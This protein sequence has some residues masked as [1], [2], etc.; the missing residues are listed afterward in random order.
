VHYVIMG[1]GVIA[2]EL[3]GR[4]RRCGQRVTVTT[5]TATRTAEILATGAE[6]VVL[7]PGRPGLGPYDPAAVHAVVAGSDGVVI[8]GR[9][10]LRFA[11]SPRERFTAY[12]HAL[13]NTVRAVTEAQRRVALLSSMVVYGDGGPGT[14]PIDE[15]TPTTTELEPAAQVFG[16][17]ERMV[18]EA[19]DG[20]VLRLPDVTGHPSDLDDVALLRF[21]HEYFTGVVP[22]SADA[23]LYRIDYRDAAAAAA[24]CLDH[25]LAGVYN[26]VPDG[27]VPRSTGTAFDKLAADAGLPPLEFRGQIKT[28]T[29]PI[30]SAKLRAAGFSF[31]YS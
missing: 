19:P 2:L 22:F 15:R 31:R 21:A 23:L 24:F 8:A 6:P 7:P 10:R 9:P 18:C 4:W 30:S 17:A 5:S 25:D 3:A 27:V 12:R 11:D 26:A 1:G 16:A 20:L 13:L 29:R 28:P 14:A